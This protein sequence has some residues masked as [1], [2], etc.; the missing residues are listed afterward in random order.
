M[1]WVG[2]FRLQVLDVCGL[3]E[4]LR[5]TNL[6]CFLATKPPI[7]M[8]PFPNICFQNA[9]SSRSVSQKA[10]NILC[11]VLKFSSSWRS[12]LGALFGEGPHSQQSPVTPEEVLKCRWHLSFSQKEPR[13]LISKLGTCLR[14]YSL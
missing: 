3:G 9:L 2:I 7:T 1:K 8:E 14:C 13:K 6:P 11:I 12:R 5:E 4:V 10:V